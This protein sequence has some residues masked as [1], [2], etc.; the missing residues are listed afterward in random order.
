MQT[1]A[2]PSLGIEAWGV[3]GFP[4]FRPAERALW[5]VGRAGTAASSAWVWGQISNFDRR[6]RRGRD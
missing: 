5:P 1:R 2:P 4:R 3:S 6:V